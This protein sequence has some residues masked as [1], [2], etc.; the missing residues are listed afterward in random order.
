LA[1]IIAATTLDYFF[2]G[3][4][5]A[6]DLGPAT[7]LWLVIFVAVAVFLNLLQ[8]SQ[9][10]MTAALSLEAKRKSH[11][12]AVLAHELRNFLSPVSSAVGVLRVQTANIELNAEMCAI[13]DRQI[14]NM[15]SLI[16]DLLDAGRIAQGKFSLSLETIDV[17]DAVADAV[18]SI[19]ALME[20]RGHDFQTTLAATP[21]SIRGDRVRLEQVLVNLLTNAAKYTDQGGKIR[22]LA[23][24]EGDEIVVAVKDNG[25]GISGELLPHVFDLFMQAEPGAHGGLGIGLNLARGLVQRHGGRIC[26]H[27]DGLGC[28]SEFV[29]HLPALAQR[30]EMSEAAPGEE[31]SVMVDAE[32]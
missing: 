30:T 27:S 32:S 4:L 26:A 31:R 11:F 12:M 2:V 10:R 15:T 17:R 14:R 16:N 19:R 22:L 5:Y 1:T 3:K 9:R 21:L 8:E 25:C 23:L 29:V 7:W 28:G 24:R 18:Q 6:L 20:E 13:I